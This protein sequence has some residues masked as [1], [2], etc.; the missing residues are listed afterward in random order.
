M[1]CNY[2]EIKEENDHLKM[3]IR[4]LNHIV[5][6]YKE[7]QY[8]EIAKRCKMEFPNFLHLDRNSNT[9]AFKTARGRLCFSLAKFDFIYVDTL[10]DLLKSFMELNQINEL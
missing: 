6:K 3:E 7:L 5:E 1:K 2:K 4:K 8:R 10:I 9:L